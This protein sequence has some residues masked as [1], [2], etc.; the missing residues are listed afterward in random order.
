MNSSIKSP[1]LTNFAEFVRYFSSNKELLRDAHLR[2]V[3]D[4]CLPCLIP[5]DFVFKLETA[6]VDQR[7]L[8]TSLFNDSYQSSLIKNGRTNATLKQA[9]NRNFTQHLHQYNLI[10]R[11]VITSLQRFYKLDFSLFGYDV[12]TGSDNRTLAVRCV[13]VL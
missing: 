6:D 12:S 7:F 9:Q 5:Y 1:L 10:E 4:R 13:I 11:D 8:V 2:P 3:S